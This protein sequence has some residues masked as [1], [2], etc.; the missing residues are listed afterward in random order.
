MSQEKLKQCSICK[1]SGEMGEEANVALTSIEENGCFGWK[2]NGTVYPYEHFK[3]N[4]TNLKIKFTE[5]HISENSNRK[6]NP[7][8]KGTNVSDA[9][10]ENRWNKYFQNEMV[11]TKSSLL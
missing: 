2:T 11:K 9:R 5:H 4:T 7:I 1:I 10:S 3:K 8:F 6:F